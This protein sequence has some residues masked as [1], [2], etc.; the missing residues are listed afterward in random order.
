MKCKICGKNADSEYCF[1][2]KPRKTFKKSGKKLSSGIQS[3]IKH[4][5]MYNVTMSELST[6]IRDVLEASESKFIYRTDKNGEKMIKEATLMQAFFMSIWNK[7]PH[8]SEVSGQYLG[9]E[10]LS[11]FFHHILAKS[12]HPELAYIEENIILLTLDEHT[13]VENDM[14]RYDEINKRR[15]LL[16]N[17][18]LNQ[19]E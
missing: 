5:R 7:L 17:K 4:Q 9:N 11:T 8:K 14:Y 3:A 19:N 6:A 13:N 18:Y 16:I 10:A 12:K 1:Q 15:E 2:H